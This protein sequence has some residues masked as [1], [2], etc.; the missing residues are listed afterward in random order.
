MTGTPT[1][2]EPE[3]R[4]PLW[5]DAE[6]SAT[7]VRSA[8]I[9][10]EIAAGARS[11]AVVRHPLSFY[12]FP[13]YRHDGDGLC[14][15]YWPA[16]DPGAPEAENDSVHSHSWAMR[17]RVL[18]GD[19]V[20]RVFA[21]EDQDRETSLELYLV[22]NHGGHDEIQPTSRAVTCRNAALHMVGPGETYELGA[23]IF[24]ATEGA[25]NGPIVTVVSG[26]NVP[27]QQNLLV[28]R[29]GLA[30]RVT[31]RQTLAAPESARLARTVAALICPY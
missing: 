3:T 14:I 31:T 15:H 11:C 7:K 25:S 12:C 4:F 13:F 2:A 26:R 20:N 5:T 1:R 21:V 29:A 6:P 19:I 22:E 8:R 18:V 27:H 17:S 16:A 24:H 28:D 10:L 9:L 30:R 23:G